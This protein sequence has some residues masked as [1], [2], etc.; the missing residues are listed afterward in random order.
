MNL[1]YELNLK[2]RVMK[3][4]LLIPVAALLII[5]CGLISKKEEIQQFIPGT[6]TRFSE[7]EFG[8]EYDTLIIS[9]Q[10]AAANEYRIVRRWKYE[11]Q[12]EGQKIEP[13]YKIK[14]S[15]AILNVRHNLLQEI[16]T[17][18]IYT[19]DVSAKCIFS[20]TVKYKKL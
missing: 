17:G 5:G 19:V 18:R 10:S 1:N 7:H 16:S 2:L 20:D 11:R 13:E 9:L 14:A 3:E 15:V 4:L 8:K 12:V 6:Y